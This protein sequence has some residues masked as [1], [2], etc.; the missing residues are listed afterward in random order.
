MSPNKFSLHSCSISSIS[1]H[2]LTIQ[3]RRRSYIF[4]LDFIAQLEMVLMAFCSITAM[5]LLFSCLL[6]SGYMLQKKRERERESRKLNV[7]CSRGTR[8]DAGCG[9]GPAYVSGALKSKPWGY[10]WMKLCG[11]RSLLVVHCLERVPCCSPDP[12][13]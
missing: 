4:K 8:V 12:H 9:H 10:E 11:R 5:Q 2:Y 3:M 1:G 6:R 7:M 13:S